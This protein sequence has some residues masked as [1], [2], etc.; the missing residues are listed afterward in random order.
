MFL[1]WPVILICAV[2]FMLV[3]TVL[4]ALIHWP[5]AAA[6]VLGGLTVGVVRR[7]LR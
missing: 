4:I 2:A 6:F 5:L 1:F 7:R 3:A